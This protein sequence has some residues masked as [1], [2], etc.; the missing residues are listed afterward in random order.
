ML[1]AFIFAS[2]SDEAAIILSKGADD[3]LT[4]DDGSIGFTPPNDYVAIKEALSEVAA[5]PPSSAR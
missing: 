5:S 3:V 2:K 4:N 1:I